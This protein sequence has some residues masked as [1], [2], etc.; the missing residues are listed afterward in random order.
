[1]LSPEGDLN[2]LLP[3]RLCVH[4]SSLPPP[5]F[6]PTT[7]GCHWAQTGGVMHPSVGKDPCTPSG[8]GSPPTPCRRRW[9]RPVGQSV[10]YKQTCG[11]GLPKTTG[12]TGVGA[13][14]LQAPFRKSEDALG[15][16]ARSA[17][18]LPQGP[19]GNQACSGSVRRRVQ[20]RTW[21]GGPQLE[22]CP[23]PPDPGT[24]GAMTS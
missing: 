22:R 13:D 24:T 1:M 7:H 8:E 19:A 4:V 11:N 16:A 3:A 12:G 18:P 6:L 9:Q 17:D 5:S 20:V 10:I 21:L 15:R 23:V 2:L 14:H